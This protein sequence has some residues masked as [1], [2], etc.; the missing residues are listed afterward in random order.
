MGLKNS[1]KLIVR[2]TTVHSYAILF[3]KLFKVA[4]VMFKQVFFLAD[5][6]LVKFVR[7]RTNLADQVKIAKV[8]DK[9]FS[10]DF[11]EV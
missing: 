6:V 11:H 3:D 10:Y 2:N 4:L 1:L 9:T 8:F 5:H 7:S